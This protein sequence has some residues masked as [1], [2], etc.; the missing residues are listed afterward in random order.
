MKYNFQK[1]EEI[2]FP[3]ETKPKLKDFLIKNFEIP[4]SNTD[5]IISFIKKT[6]IE[7]LIYD[8]PK[9]IRT[10]FYNDKL[11]I[12][13][14]DEHFE[15][16]KILEI[17]VLSSFDGDISVDKENRIYDILYDNYD[18]NNVDEIFINM[19]YSHD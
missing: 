10:E 17:T 8:L 14:S 9:I 5:E 2:Y 6:K 3:Y 7:S 4:N 15:N 16:K 18:W 12:N 1:A 11:Q 19:E 13:I